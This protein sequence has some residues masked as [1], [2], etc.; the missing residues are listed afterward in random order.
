[1]AMGLYLSSLPALAMAVV[2][3]TVAALPP[4]IS[5]PS[6]TYTLCVFFGSVIVVMLPMLEVVQCACKAVFICFLQ[7]THVGGLALVP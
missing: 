4:M 2:V 7:V 6:S 3:I 1:M 5:L